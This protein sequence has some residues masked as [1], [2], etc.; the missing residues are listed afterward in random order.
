[1]VVNTI[2]YPCTGKCVK[3]PCV[4]DK[5]NTNK[6]NK[7][8]SLSFICFCSLIFL[9]VYERFMSFPDLTNPSQFMWKF[10]YISTENYIKLH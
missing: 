10:E 3:I 8:C 4:L 6:P 5:I 9:F 7:I 2:K 1:M